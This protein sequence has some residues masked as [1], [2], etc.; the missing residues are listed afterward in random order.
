MPW[1][2]PINNNTQPYTLRSK[3]S[4]LMH[5]QKIPLREL[6]TKLSKKSG[7]NRRSILRYY[8]DRDP[9][10][11]PTVRNYLML[12]KVLDIDLN[13]IVDALANNPEGVDNPGT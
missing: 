9:L 6:A 3:M 12:C 5:E 8:Y 7:A 10:Y 4:E 13:L 1:P 2:K 11:N